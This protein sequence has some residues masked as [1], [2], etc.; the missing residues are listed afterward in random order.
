M[1]WQLLLV[2][3]MKTTDRWLHVPIVSNNK[4][5]QPTDNDL[6]LVQVMNLGLLGM[7]PGGRLNIKMSSY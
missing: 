4:I 7:A 6:A 1:L 5:F 3:Q 2:Y